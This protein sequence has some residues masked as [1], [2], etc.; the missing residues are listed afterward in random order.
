MNLHLSRATLRAALHKP[1]PGGAG[2][3][4][5]DDWLAR[6]LDG[7]VPGSYPWPLS[8]S[9]QGE[10]LK[11][12]AVMIALCWR[13]DN[14]GPGTAKAA[15]KG[16]GG[17]QNTPSQQPMIL[18]TQRTAHLSQHAGQIGFPGGRVDRG[19]RDIIV[20]AQRET[21]EEVGLEISD[22]QIIGHLPAYITRTRYHISPVVAWV[23]TAPELS[24]L[25]FNPEEVALLFEI[26]LSFI[27]NPAN[28][29]QEYRQF[30]GK[31]VP[32]FAF[33][34]QEHYIWGATAGMLVALRQ[35]LVFGIADKNLVEDR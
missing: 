27:L 6:Q 30:A 2:L 20:T 32:F 28:C 17:G 12:A 5:G 25:K 33:Q 24:Q 31:N 7:Q 4:N 10:P 9:F 22:Q 23:E 1:V 26:P 14:K 34:Y 16:G 21:R 29:R 18:L 8:A 11:A 15:R 19:D 13:E 3:P 35:Q